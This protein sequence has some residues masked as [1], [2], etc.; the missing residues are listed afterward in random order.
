MLDAFGVPVDPLDG[1]AGRLAERAIS[2]CR[3]GP[4]LLHRFDVEPEARKRF[5]KELEVLAIDGGLRVPVAVDLLLAEA[6]QALRVI[7][8]KHL[9]RAAN[10]LAVLGQGR[11][12]GTLRVIA[13]KGVEHLLHPP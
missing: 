1:L 8:A 3:S 7:L 4:L 2:R 11:E 9:Q 6:E 13:E 10:L 12:H 5:G